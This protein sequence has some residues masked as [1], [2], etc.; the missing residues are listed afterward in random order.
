ML[1]AHNFVVWVEGDNQPC[2]RGIFSRA[3]FNKAKQKKKTKPNQVCLIGRRLKL[4][5]STATSIP[6]S[7]ENKQ[8][9]RQ[10]GSA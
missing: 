6:L 7:A 9:K 8:N 4:H 10:T 3:P 1:G 2:T 5:H